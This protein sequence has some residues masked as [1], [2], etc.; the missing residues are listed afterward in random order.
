MIHI[1]NSGYT[2]PL[3]LHPQPWSL[4]LLSLPTPLPSTTQE[5]LVRAW[6]KRWSQGTDSDV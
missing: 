1:S 4:R 3:S 6:N 2:N 5:G